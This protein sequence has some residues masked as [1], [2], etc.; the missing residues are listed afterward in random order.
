MA[1]VIA[2]KKMNMHHNL[3]MH[4]FYFSVCIYKGDGNVRSIGFAVDKYG[5]NLT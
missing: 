1:L 5:R 3:P 4:L 2:N